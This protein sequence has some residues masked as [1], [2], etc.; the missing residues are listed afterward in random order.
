M[1]A[2]VHG[3][4]PGRAEHQATEVDGMEPVDVLVGVDGEEGTL[5]VEAV[6]QRQLDQEG[7]DLRVGV[8]AGDGL[9]QLLLGGGRGQVLADR[10]DAE[11]GAVLVLQ[12][13]IALARAVVADQDGAQADVHALGGQRRP[14]GRPL[15]TGCGRPPPRRRAGWRSSVLEV[16]FAGHDHRQAGLVR[17]GDDLAVLTEPPG[18]TTAV[19][20][21]SARTRSPSGKGKKASLAPA[22]PLARSPAFWT[23][24]S[25]ATTRDCWPAPT[26]TACPPVTTAIALEVVRPQTRQASTRSRHSSS[27]GARFV[28][29]AHSGGA[30]R[31]R[32][33]PA[34]ARG[35]EAAQVPG[36]LLGRRAREQAGRPAP[37]DQGLERL[38]RVGQGDDH[39]GLRPR[40]H[41]FRHLGRHVSADGDHAAEGRTGRTRARARRP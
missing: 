34:P 38:G 3:S 12:R 37:S 29:T 41:G 8:E 5:L 32:R 25:A 33:R 20:P 27:V 9:H 40:G 4:G 16:P 24:I 13:D 31:S 22:P 30:T 18:W 35:A 28:T 7:A 17:R 21:A 1:P 10:V 36:C 11:R 19:T 6:G 23:A 15:R 14:R 2:G 26:P 39:V